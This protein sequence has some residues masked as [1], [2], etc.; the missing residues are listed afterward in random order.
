M[1]EKEK[2]PIDP[3][4]PEGMIAYINKWE[5]DHL[6]KGDAKQMNG[7]FGQVAGVF[8]KIAENCNRR[9]NSRIGTRCG[10][11]DRPINGQQMYSTVPMYDGLGKP[12]NMYSCSEKCDRELRDKQHKRAVEQQTEA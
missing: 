5:H 6:R 2:E 10:Q 3:H 11:C 9:L 4:S 12:V 7:E 8:T 1:S